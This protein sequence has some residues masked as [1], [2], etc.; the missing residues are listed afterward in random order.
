MKL[1][2]HAGRGHRA[3]MMLAVA[4]LVLAAGCGGGDDESA[5]LADTATEPATPATTTDAYAATADGQDP[6]PPPDPSTPPPAAV[7]ATAIAPLRLVPFGDSMTAGLDPSGQ[8]PG[9]AIYE[10]YRGA[11]YRAL[12]ID[13][14]EVDFLGRHKLLERLGGDP[15]HEGHPGRTIGD[16]PTVGDILDGAP[17]LF[18]QVPAILAITPAPDVIVMAFGWNS[19]NFRQTGPQDYRRIVRYLQQRLPETTLLLATLSPASG[20][21]EAQTAAA[22]PFYQPFNEMARALAGADAKDRLILA[23]LAAGG[24]DAD[25][26]RG[27]TSAGFVEVHWSAVGAER[28]ARILH[29]ALGQA[30]LAR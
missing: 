27:P 5:V 13:G 4:L 25:D 30:G 23:D 22:I 8:P 20:M 10:S 7:P 24:F 29:D 11:L 15:D 28:A 17:T 12:A 18:T 3:R 19:V 26:Y 1:P 6:E 16:S 9:T 21:S 14:R 2:L